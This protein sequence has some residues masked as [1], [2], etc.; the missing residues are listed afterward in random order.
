[1]GLELMEVFRSAKW[2]G[3]G[4]IMRA[5]CCDSRIN[6]CDKETPTQTPRRYGDQT[7]THERVVRCA[8][9][10]TAIVEEGWLEKTTAIVCRR[11]DI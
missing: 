1:M 4:Q 5:T 2:A 8:C 9:G 3:G 11:H 10:K 6:R 7:V